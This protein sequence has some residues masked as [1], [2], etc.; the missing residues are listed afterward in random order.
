MSNSNQ[1]RRH[2]P[3]AINNQAQHN[4]IAAADELTGQVRESAQAGH[5][6]GEVESNTPPTKQSIQ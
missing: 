5:V 4:E 1:D 3:D 2:V 6:G